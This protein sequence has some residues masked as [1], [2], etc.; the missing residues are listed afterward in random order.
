MAF[1]RIDVRRPDPAEL[2]QPLIEFLKWS[3][4]QPV[5]PPLCVHCGLYKPRFAKHPEML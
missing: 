2:R 3:R 1:E 5:Q 4:L